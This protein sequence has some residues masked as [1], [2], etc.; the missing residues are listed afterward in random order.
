MSAD[1]AAWLLDR[2]AEDEAVALQ[3]NSLD[4]QWVHAEWVEINDE[5]RAH[6]D[7]WHPARVLA[8]CEARRRIVDRHIRKA[9]RHLPVPPVCAECGGADWKPSGAD[10]VDPYPW[11]MPWPCP[12]L[13]LL[14]LPYADHELFREEWRV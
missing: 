7:R 2:I 9:G 1:L 10:R 12:T 4:S 13:R 5:Q 3:A 11:V 14:A 8:E 6:A